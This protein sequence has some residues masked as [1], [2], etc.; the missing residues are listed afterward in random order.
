MLSYSFAMEYPVL[1]TPLGVSSKFAQILDLYRQKEPGR[2]SAM[3][4]SIAG[5]GCFDGTTVYIS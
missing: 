5:Y 1:C 2:L 3:T 4:W